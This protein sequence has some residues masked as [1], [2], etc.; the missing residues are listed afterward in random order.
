MSQE[1]EWRE[2]IAKYIPSIEVM[3]FIGP[4]HTIKWLFDRC[5]FT[6]THIK[7]KYITYNLKECLKGFETKDIDAIIEVLQHRRCYSAQHIPYLTEEE[8]VA[9]QLTGLL[10]NFGYNGRFDYIIDD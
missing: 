10:N 9:S 6:K 5:L 1:W 8:S 3:S 4:E 7:P 2:E